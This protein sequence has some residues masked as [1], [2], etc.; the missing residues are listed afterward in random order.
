MNAIRQKEL[1]EEKATFEEDDNFEKG[2]LA[3]EDNLAEGEN[4]VGEAD[5]DSEELEE[6]VETSI[7]EEEREKH[8]EVI[9]ATM[10][11]TEVYQYGRSRWGIC[12]QLPTNSLA[13]SNC[14]VSQFCFRRIRAS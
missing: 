3:E 10:T 6:P 12:P 14:K 2:E 8:F 5:D 9:S 4:F 13:H 1:T 11:W 7:A